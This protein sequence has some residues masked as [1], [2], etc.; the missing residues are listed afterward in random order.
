MERKRNIIREEMSRRTKKAR[1]DKPVDEE[2][3]DQEI[4][5]HASYG[6]ELDVPSPRN[7]RGDTGEVK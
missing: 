6:E 1:L 2:Y 4:S 3:S 5:V 7:E